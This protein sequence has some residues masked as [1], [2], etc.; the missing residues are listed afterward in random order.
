MTMRPVPL[1]EVFR[2]IDARDLEIL[3]TVA[4]TC[5]FR[6]AGE[7]LELGQSTVSRRIQKLEELLGCPCLNAD[8]PARA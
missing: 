4:E 5:S 6:N 3:L 8:R 7:R 1:T 2:Q